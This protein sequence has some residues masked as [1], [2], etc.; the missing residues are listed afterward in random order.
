MPD[1]KIPAE[2]AVRRAERSPTTVPLRPPEVKLLEL[3]DCVR[4]AT[5]TQMAAL[6]LGAYERRGPRKQDRYSSSYR[7]HDPLARSLTKLTRSGFIQRLDQ[8]VY[9]LVRHQHGRFAAASHA[10]YALDVAGMQ[11]VGG[12]D[13]P[14]VAER[15]KNDRE[16]RPMQVLHALGITDV[17][18]TLTLAISARRDY[19]LATWLQGSEELKTVW[20]GDER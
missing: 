16:L 5:I 15:R 11:Y 1:V 4:L 18:C 20:Y 7:L 6:V 3:L 2:V 14:A 12:T 13:K 19:A 17:F 10:V 8:G 9:Y